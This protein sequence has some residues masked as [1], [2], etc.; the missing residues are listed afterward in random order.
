MNA[1]SSLLRI[2]RNSHF[3]K[4]TSAAGSHVRC[5]HT[6][7]LVFVAVS[8]LVFPARGAIL[9]GNIDGTTPATNTGNL[10]GSITGFDFIIAR[11]FAI[12]GGVNYRLE[13]VQLT[14]KD[15]H[16]PIAPV[17][18]IREDVAGLPGATL[19]TLAN[20]VSFSGGRTNTDYTFTPPAS[21]TFHMGTS[22]HLVVANA[23]SPPSNLPFSWANSDPGTVPSGI[24]TDTGRTHSNDNGATFHDSGPL[25]PARFQIEATP[26]PE[27]T[28]GL[29]I[30]LVL[31]GMLLRRKS[32]TNSSR[33]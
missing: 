5:V 10:V 7:G 4:S 2:L 26:V 33:S 30:A 21:F 23:N 3:C 20:P 29:F 24:A 13:S 25:T 15:H 28:A 12:P 27:P 16:G 32:N 31:S 1:V 19:A 6:L 18:T 11:G 9:I 17:V 8:F 22:Y 14:L